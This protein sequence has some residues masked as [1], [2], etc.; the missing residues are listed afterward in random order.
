MQMKPLSPKAAFAAQLETIRRSMEPADWLADAFEVLEPWL[1]TL[2][3]AKQACLKIE[4]FPAVADTPT[5]SATPAK[6][7]LQGEGS[8]GAGKFGYY[9]CVNKKVVFRDRTQQVDLPTEAQFQT[10]ITNL[11][12]SQLT[13]TIG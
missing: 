12:I 13:A 1:A 2:P 3:G 9:Y 10:H 11:M 6:L 4:H 5:R 7:E 8:W